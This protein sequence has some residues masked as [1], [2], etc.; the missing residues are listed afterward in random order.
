MSGVRRTKGTPGTTGTPKMGVNSPTPSNTVL[1]T[2]TSKEPRLSNRTPPHFQPAGDG[3]FC[4]APFASEIADVR[5]WNLR[6]LESKPPAPKRKTRHASSSGHEEAQRRNLAPELHFGPACYASQAA[7]SKG[8]NQ[9][10]RIFSSGDWGLT[11]LCTRVPWGRASSLVLGTSTGCRKKKSREKRRTLEKK[12]KKE[13]TK[14]KT[15][16]QDALQGACFRESEASVPSP[17]MRIMP[18][19]PGVFSP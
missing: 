11:N 7:N 18:T 9:Q 8:Q 3:A 15:R 14:N 19:S 16:E 10:Q 6:H 2:A 4:A 5:T 17:S 13:K 1:T 12:K